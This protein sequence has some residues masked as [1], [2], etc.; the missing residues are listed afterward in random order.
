LERREPGRASIQK[1]E[2]PKSINRGL[3]IIHLIGGGILRNFTKDKGRDSFISK[4]QFL[5]EETTLD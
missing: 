2:G 1:D 3:Q 4:C 5:P